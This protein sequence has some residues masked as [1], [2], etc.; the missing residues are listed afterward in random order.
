MAEPI[1]SEKRARQERQAQ[2]LKS[3]YEI[4]KP[5]S[6]V[7]QIIGWSQSKVSGALN[8]ANFVAKVK[9]RK[10][11]ELR[12]DKD[13]ILSSDS[14]SVE[15]KS[16]A[17]FKDEVWNILD[18]DK[19]QIV[20]D[21]VG[22]IIELQS[23]DF[24]GNPELVQERDKTVGTLIGSLKTAGE[25]IQSLSTLKSFGHQ[26]LIGV[27]EQMDKGAIDGS[28]ILVPSE[29]DLQIATIL[30]MAG[31][32]IEFNAEEGKWGS[33]KGAKPEFE[34]FNAENIGALCRYLNTPQH[35]RHDRV[36]PD[37][38]LQVYMEVYATKLGANDKS[39]SGL[40]AS[41]IAI[42]VT[43]QKKKFTVGSNEY[44]ITRLLDND[45]MLRNAQRMAMVDAFEV[46]VKTAGDT[47]AIMSTI[48]K[49]ANSST[50]PFYKKQF[51]HLGKLSS[52]LEGVYKSFDNATDLIF[53]LRKAMEE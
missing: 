3:V 50:L 48:D 26:G 35:E 11:T 33:V 7:S 19:K 20:L 29:E 53:A 12:A 27:L 4:K 8:W 51:R 17:I 21:I 23:A 13:S 25:H 1:K 44:N 47:K 36:V 41:R 2:F 14:V 24:G 6:K 22:D 32:D 16:L 30:K 31:N 10:S 39:K 9:D 37:K 40:E 15:V 52:V 28:P 43:E 38:L 5:E 46:V 18:N 49:T 45:T 34:V 42:A